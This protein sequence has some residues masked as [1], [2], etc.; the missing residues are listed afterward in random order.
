MP[1]I[2]EVMR[3]RQ[4]LCEFQANHSYLVRPYLKREKQTNERRGAQAEVAHTCL[5]F[6]TG[7]PCAAPGCPETHFVN[8]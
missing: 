6:K 3:Q 7:F 4:D 5:L 1:L 2:T 8:P